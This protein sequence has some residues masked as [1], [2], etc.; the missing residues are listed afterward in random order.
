[1]VATFFFPRLGKMITDE[2]IRQF[3]DNSN[4]ELLE[5]G[6]EPAQI[7]NIVSKAHRFILSNIWILEDLIETLK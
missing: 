6:Q 1:M 4:R 5:E 3:L 7:R 2:K